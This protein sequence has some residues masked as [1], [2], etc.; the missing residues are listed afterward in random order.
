MKKR[1]NLANI[2]KQR[3][4]LFVAV[5]PYVNLPLVS[6]TLT[7]FVADVYRAVPPTISHDLI[8][9]SCRLLAG[10]VLEQKK[11]AEF[12]WRLAGNMHVLSAGQPVAPWTRQVSEE[13]MP[14]LVTHADP[15]FRR[16][17]FG[18][19][20]RCQALAGSYCPHTF[21]QFMSKASCA[22]ISRRVGFSRAV[23]YTNP[24]Y[25]TRLHLLVLADPVKS[26][27]CPQ[28]QQVDCSPAMKARNKRIIKVRL[29]QLPCPKN[30]DRLCEHCPV[31]AEQCKASLFPRPLESRYC[32]TCNKIAYF[33][34]TRSDS[35]CL[36]C[37][38]AKRF[39][40][41]AGT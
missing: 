18:Q 28:F 41:P 21:E 3:D 38:G 40:N 4:K 31:G 1:F 5:R 22:A 15:A 26:V 19:I 8:F 10:V 30:Y 17:K 32:P 6:D 12:A 7:D 29:R 39:R 37:W 24:A 13:W 11:A 36:K 35:L 14:V 27:E 9:E 23:P 33:D 2:A 16:G 20:L 25:F 34:M